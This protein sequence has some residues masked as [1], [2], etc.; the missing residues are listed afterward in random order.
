MRAPD[1]D[2]IAVARAAFEALDARDWRALLEYVDP[3]ALP[4]VKE[5][6]IS[7]VEHV[8]VRKPATPE[9]IQQ[10]QPGL[11]RPVAEWFAE[12]EWRAMA[13]EE[14]AGLRSM[15]V[16]SIDELRSLPDDEVFV[17]WLSA[18]DVAERKRRMSAQPSGATSADGPAVSER[19]PVRKEV[20]GVVVEGDEAH[21]LYRIPEGIWRP[22]QVESLTWTKLGWRLSVNGIVSASL[23]THFRI[24]LSA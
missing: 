9:E 3:A 5:Q 21:V 18:T 13:A 20:F 15:S 12:E 19:P 4:A 16:G 14:P 2:P 1:E 11:P 6:A 23:R 17:R 10:R 8:S 24:I 7:F 22:V